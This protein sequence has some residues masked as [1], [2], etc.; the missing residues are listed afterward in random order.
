MKNKEKYAKEIVEIACDGHDI[1]VNKNTGKPESCKFL[2]CNECLFSGHGNQSC[3]DV[4]REWAESECELLDELTAE[5]AIKIQAEICNNSMPCVRCAIDKANDSHCNCGEFRSKNPDKVLEILKQWKKDHETGQNKKEQKT[6]I[7]NLIK[8][9]KEVGN[10]ET[11]IYAYEIDMNKEDVDEK[12][13]E[14]VK[15]YYEKYGDKIYA[16]Y[17]RI[18]RIKS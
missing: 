8:V 5:E 1:A 3:N 16:K 11:C 18:C 13:K 4:T 17:E 10:D 14:L 12:M 9:M 6:E 2:N 15:K 7:V